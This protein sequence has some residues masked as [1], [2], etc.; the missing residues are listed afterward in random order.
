M[1]SSSRS[2]RSSGWAPPRRP[3][4][5]SPFLMTEVVW[6]ADERCLDVAY[7]GGKGASLAR[8][9]AEGLPVPPG[10]VIP[11]SALA[12]AVDGERLA[13]LAGAGDHEGAQAVV[14]GA[15]PGGPEID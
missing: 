7:A 2:S 6:F 13:E 8:M 14:L 3:S 1:A 4:A 11:S 15:E 9:A 5:R 12:K 10:F